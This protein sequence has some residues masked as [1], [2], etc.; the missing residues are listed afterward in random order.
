MRK[1]S[2][3][4]LAILLT[5]VMLFGIANMSLSFAKVT[6]NASGY[7]FTLDFE[8]NPEDFYYDR[9]IVW[10]GGERIQFTGS[11]AKISKDQNA[12][13]ATVRKMGA[14]A[15][16]IWAEFRCRTP[17]QGLLSGFALA[18]LTQTLRTITVFGL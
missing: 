12:G 1:R 10:D 2:R 6:K 17:K 5:F 4:S 8:G 9:N 13:I 7:T 18:I 15:S 11:E 14:Y 3:K 16:P